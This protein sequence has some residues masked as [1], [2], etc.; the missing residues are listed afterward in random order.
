M[1]EVTENKSRYHEKF[2]SFSH[3]KN[4]INFVLQD[5]DPT[6]YVDYMEKP[7]IVVMHFPPAFFI[8]GTPTE[9]S[10]KDVFKLLNANSWIIT[11]TEDWKPFIEGHYGKSVDLHERILFNNKN[12]TVERVRRHRLDLPTNLRIQPIEEIHTQKGIIYEDVV[13][14]FFQKSPFIQNGFGFVLLDESN[15][16][17][18]FALTNYPI[19]SNEIEL[20]FRVGYDSFEKY[21]HQGV[22]TILCTY[23]I[24]EA[25]NRGLVPIWDSAHALSAHIAEKLGYE[26]EYK[27]TMY[28]V[29]KI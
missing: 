22:G 27:W 28:H 25:L 21:R 20:Y 8:W 14:R 12:V 19:T 17:Q 11:D 16:P 6:I 1:I 15:T 29:T 18:G 5:Y 26:V 4:F 13:S 24:E 9:D 10:T 7:N 2:K 23:F 3:F